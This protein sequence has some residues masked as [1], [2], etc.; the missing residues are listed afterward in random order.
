MKKNLGNGIVKKSIIVA[1]S[2]ML[3]TTSPVVNVVAAEDT[4]TTQ[5]VAED[6]QTTQES[7][8]S[9]DFGE[10]A[11][12]LTDD[13][14]ALAT[15][16]ADNLKEIGNKY[17]DSEYTEKEVIDEAADVVEEKVTEALDSQVEEATKVADE[18]EATAKEVTEK[19]EEVS[20]A[21]D[22]YKEATDELLNADQEIVASVEG[23]TDNIVETIT[24][25][26]DVLLNVTDENGEKVKVQDYTE[27]KATVAKDAVDEAQE[28]LDN[29]TTSSN[30]A[31]ERAKIDEA[32][33]KAETAKEEAETAYNAAKSVLV[34]EIKRYN[35]YAT[36]YGYD[37]YVYEGET[38]TYTEEEL[39]NLSDLSM[40]Q[41]DIENG[42]AEIDNAAW[43][44]QTAKL[45][46]AAHM[47]ET[48]S[49]AVDMADE[50]IK[51]FEDAEDRL[52]ANLEH[53][54]TQSQNAMNTA[55]SDDKKEL[56]KGMYESVKALYD[57]YTMGD[58]TTQESYQA[59]FN[60]ADE[61]ANTLADTVDQ[62]V[63]TAK[64]DLEQ[65]VAR[66]NTAY[67][68]YQKIK[69]EYDNYVAGKNAV[70]TNF[71]DLKN[72][73]ANAEA[74]VLA[75][76]NDVQI[77]IDAVNDANDI[78]KSFEDAVATPE[79]EKPENND[80]ENNNSGSGSD[81]P[82]NDSSNTNTDSS[83]AVSGNTSN[84]TTSNTSSSDV[85]T[86]ED[87]ITPLTA[88]VTDETATI[89]D[90]ATPLT[91]TIVDEVTPLAD[92]VPKTGDASAA[93]GA[94]GAS[95]LAAMVGAL[96]LNLKKRTL[97]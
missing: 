84:G 48:C 86:L 40:T 31:E 13:E 37:L 62:A 10:A 65:E 27:E 23:N 1:M 53:M 20:S 38:L 52:L 42:L 90:E 49:Q 33:A 92:A 24:K 21:I 66:Y 95:G 77:A 81:T 61:K 94:V 85:L 89:A 8:D 70:D 19:A 74:A 69:A 59:I 78:K 50:V 60:Y 55:T 30:V 7:T 72:K 3:I 91:A 96:F 97:R 2:F 36:K 83:A 43:E 88:A 39:A 80:S 45:E 44:D 64:N 76:Q 22:N 9:L 16:L 79:E 18:A 56:Y 68:E 63:E 6:V 67:A 82:N 58:E 5:E 32:V 51:K 75:A 35:A 87:V 47:V 14:K 34:D 4:Q 73:L 28:I 12:Y 25:E 41:T 93:A 15:D 26:G 71:E 29:I 46:N 57:V 11:D 17:N 54:M